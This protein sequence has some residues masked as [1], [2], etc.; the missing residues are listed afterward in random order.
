MATV[1]YGSSSDNKYIHT[2]FEILKLDVRV[3]T[4][5][6]LTYTEMCRVYQR[7]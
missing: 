2:Y 4:I 7:S 3:D 1:N 6:R 5:S